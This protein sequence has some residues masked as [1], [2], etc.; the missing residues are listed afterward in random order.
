MKLVVITGFLL[1]CHVLPMLGQENVPVRK[2]I[3]LQAVLHGNYLENDWFE[4][5][6]L[7][8]RYGKHGVNGGPL[9]G[10]NYRWKYPIAGMFLSYNYYP[11]FEFKR[12]SG[13]AIV[14]YQH[15]KHPSR[16]YDFTFQGGYGLS[17]RLVDRLFIEQSLTAG[18]IGTYAPK[19]VDFYYYRHH[20]YDFAMMFRFGIR[21][22]FV[23]RDAT[24]SEPQ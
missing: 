8:I 24:T 20:N 18:A 13:S 22:E 17:Y 9:L 15:E 23:L 11:D 5:P 2:Q 10:Y 3:A 6:G 12:F 4:S 16:Y 21:Y 14:Y 7:G 1:V 19:E